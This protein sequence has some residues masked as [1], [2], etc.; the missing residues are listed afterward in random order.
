M[1]RYSNE[2]LKLFSSLNE[3]QRL[4]VDVGQGL[5]CVSACAGSGKTLSLV[6]R[7][8]RLVADGLDPKFILAMTFTRAAAA[9]METRLSKLGIT[10]ARVGTIHS[11]CRQILAESRHRILDS[12]KL[13]EKGT[14]KYELKKILW[15]L[16][17]KRRLNLWN[18][19]LEWVERYISACKAEGIVH[20]EGDP[21]G[22]N[23]YSEL[24]TY[25]K[26]LASS[27]KA[28]IRPRLL[29]EILLEL[30]SRRSAAGL[31]DYDD[32][33]SWAW[34]LLV[35]DDGERAQWRGRYSVV[36]IDEAMDSTKV[37]WDI[38]RFLVGLNSCF[39]STETVPC[40]P[41]AD[42]EDHNLM[43]IGDPAQ[44]LYSFRNAYPKEFVDFWNADPVKKIS[45]TL[46]YRSNVEI[47]KFGTEIIKGRK[48]NLA[49]KIVAADQKEVKGKIKTIRYDTI[50]HEATHTIHKCKE[51]AQTS[52]LRSCAVLG[53]MKVSLDL[54]EI[55]CIR[56]RIKYVK[57]ASGSFFESKETQ[58][59]LAYLRVAAGYDQTGYWIRHLINRP[60]RYIGNEFIQTAREVSRERQIPLLEAMLGVLG[61]KLA[62]RQTR[63]LE[64]LSSL[65]M[66]IHKDAARAEK[67]KVERLIEDEAAKKAEEAKKDKET[68]KDEAAKKDKETKKGEAAIAPEDLLCGPANGISMMLRDTKY[69]ESIKSED[70]LNKFDDSK[71]I[72][73]EALRRIARQFVSYGEFLGFVDQV[74]NAVKAAKKSGLKVTEGS[75]EDALILSTIHRSKGLEF[76]H[77]FVVDVS[78][79]IFPARKAEDQEEE[80]RLFYVAATRAMK[81]CTISCG[82]NKAAE[83]IFFAEARK[84]LEGIH[85]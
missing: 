50:E 41:I 33:L 11:L 26:A 79:G 84:I 73:V 66:R 30:E 58:D 39:L 46:N 9:E 5:C 48:W 29:H 76:Q 3:Q 24:F 23:L 78:E 70:G 34:M 61:S 56:S 45:L 44:S 2:L 65:L 19:D 12:V 55:E 60:F 6:A 18:V 57:M 42:N 10:G 77:V 13:D 22:L 71:E 4:V 7:V 21:F 80:L 1:P 35:A 72:A 37:Q 75:R 74:I 82:G 15:D 52:G 63:A 40:A 85:R 53:R 59:V 20:V 38:A 51:I 36:L 16:R 25:R 67:N 83:S 81:T 28:G 8:A 17:R 54:A 62:T 68:K 14:M 27:S 31:F 32:M 64:S 43:V 49:G 47:C 69:L